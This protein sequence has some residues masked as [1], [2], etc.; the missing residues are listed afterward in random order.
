M[1]KSGDQTI[2]LS[3]WVKLLTFT[4]RAGYPATVITNNALVMDAAVSGQVRWRGAFNAVFGTQQFRVVR[5]GSTVIGTVNNATIGTVNGVAVAIGDTL[6]LQG[7]A[8]ING[9]NTVVGGGSNTFLEFNQ[10]TINHD[11]DPATTTIGWNVTADAE[12]DHPADATTT[13]GW[14][15]TADVHVPGDQPAEA[16]VT[17]GWDLTADVARTPG[18]GIH[19]PTPP[20]SLAIGIRTVDGRPVGVIACDNTTDVLWSR[21]RSEVSR[22]EI[23]TVDIDTSELLPWHHWI[24]IFENDVAVW[25]GPI[26]EARTAFDTGVTRIEARDVAG[27]MWKT[28]T[29]VTGRWSNLDPAPIAAALWRP[30]LELHRVDVDPTVLPPTILERFDFSTTAEA[31]YL[32]QVMSD[33]VR[34]GLEW[35]VVAGRP[36]LGTFDDTVVAELDDCDIMATLHRVRSG[37]RVASDVR[38]QG[39]NWAHTERVDMAGLRLQALVS[40]DDMFGVSNIVSAARQYLRE[41]GALRDVL[42]V[43]AGASLHPDAPVTTDDLVPGRAWAIH[44]GG[45]AALM[46]LKTV[47]VAWS[48]GSRDV[49]VTLE[50]I[51]EPVE[52][53]PGN[54]GIAL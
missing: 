38:V 33:L 24:D 27:F 11:A 21:A 14:D 12:V 7:F 20:T 23:H 30:M 17:V 49:R 29:P 44:A 42:E 18:P 52:L 31:R 6:E 19:P 46:R 2:A 35:T 32:N 13:I 37:K 34:I 41:V 51:T 4:V 15:I 5:N 50:A 28:L 40:L 26:L 47:E 9:A 39:R 3:T 22:A 1:D 43:P 45:L 36:I 25:S 48:G 8:N 54:G 53:D 16:T 10:T